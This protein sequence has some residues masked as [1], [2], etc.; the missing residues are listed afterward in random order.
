MSL[1]RRWRPTSLTQKS[2]R[3]SS[4]NFLEPVFLL[5]ESYVL[6][7]IPLAPRT[8]TRWLAPIYLQP[9]SLHASSLVV[10]Y[11]YH[12][13]KVNPVVSYSFYLNGELEWYMLKVY[14]AAQ[15]TGAFLGALLAFSLFSLRASKA[16]ENSSFDWMLADIFG[17]VRE[18]NR[19]SNRLWERSCSY[20][21]S[22]SKCT[23]RPNWPTTTLPA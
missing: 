10:M 16:S 14:S 19:L 4:S 18:M 7:L 13:I 5:T 1:N 21:S 9:S 6:K 2:R 17:E 23:R 8:V 12:I 20:S 11:T 3:P 22:T 15:F